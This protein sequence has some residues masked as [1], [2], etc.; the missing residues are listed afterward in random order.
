MTKR[1]SKYIDDQASS[2]DYESDSEADSDN[3]KFQLRDDDSLHTSDMEFIADDDDDDE[4]DTYGHGKV[5]R[6]EGHARRD[7]HRKRH[8]HDHRDKDRSRHQSSR[9]RHRHGADDRHRNRDHGREKSKEKPSSR[10]TVDKESDKKK[11]T[12]ASVDNNKHS[13]VAIAVGKMAKTKEQQKA[14]FVE[15]LTYFI[16]RCINQLIY[17]K[18][19]QIVSGTVKYADPDLKE[20]LTPNTDATR[21]LFKKIKYFIQDIDKKYETDDQSVIGK[22]VNKFVTINSL[23][24]FN[25]HYAVTDDSDVYSMNLQA[26]KFLANLMTISNYDKVIM[27]LLAE[28]AHTMVA[29]TRLQ[30]DMY[31]ELYSLYTTPLITLMVD[32]VDYVSLKTGVNF[33]ESD[34]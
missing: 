17:E 26:A 6:P 23:H 13:Q 16:T 32:A 15:N 28:H 34:H 10:T 30:P 18:C 31:N 2:S 9:H 27:S 24:Y 7:K 21:A 11:Q 8:G 4:E 33:W 5:S 12:H 3:S 25:G 22:I 29:T 19:D 20:K 14:S 1:H